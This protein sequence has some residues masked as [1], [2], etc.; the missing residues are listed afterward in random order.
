MSLTDIIQFAFLIPLSFA[1]YLKYIELK[2]QIVGVE[3]LSKEIDKL[4]LEIPRLKVEIEKLKSDLAQGN[5]N[6]VLELLSRKRKIYDVC[7]TI[8]KKTEEFALSYPKKNASNVKLKNLRAE[9]DRLVFS[10]MLLLTEESCAIADY[11]LENKQ[12][13]REDFIED[14]ILQVLEALECHLHD[15]NRADILINLGVSKSKLA[16]P[17]LIHTIRFL[18]NTKSCIPKIKAEALILSLSVQT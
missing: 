13:R 6:H 14:I 4:N 1:F 12:E 3:K 17:D 2:S 8:N 7:Y 5:I 10:E 18:K 9:I 16:R 11:F 15:F